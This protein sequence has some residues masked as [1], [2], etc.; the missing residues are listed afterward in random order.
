MLQT[1]K[2]RDLTHRV[3]LVEID[4]TNDNLVMPP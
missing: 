2:N 4:K 1:A 3:Y